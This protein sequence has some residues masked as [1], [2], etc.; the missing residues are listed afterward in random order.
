[1]LRKVI[2]ILNGF[3]QENEKEVVTKVYGVFAPSLEH[4]SAYIL[5]HIF[6]WVKDAKLLC[7]NNVLEVAGVPRNR[8]L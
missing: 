4:S 5:S 6:L 1:M 7:R 8:R 2:S 3:K